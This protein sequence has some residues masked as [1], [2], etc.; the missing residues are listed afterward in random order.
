MRPALIAAGMTV[1]TIALATHY[2][3]AGFG[4][5]AAA[6]VALIAIDAILEDASR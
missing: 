3:L 1:V 5:G 2:G 6:A 4:V